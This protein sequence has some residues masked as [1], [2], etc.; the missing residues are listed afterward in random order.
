M[1]LTEDQRELLSDYSWQGDGEME[2]VFVGRQ[3]LFQL[4]AQNARMCVKGKNQGRTVCIAGPPGAGK[5]AF[6]QAL[7]ERAMTDG[8]GGPK[9]ACISI[10]PKELQ[11]PVALLGHIARQLPEAWRPEVGGIRAA[12]GRL[13][14][15]SLNLNLFGVGGAIE[16]DT[17]AVQ[18]REGSFPWGE[19]TALLSGL[20]PAAAACICVD[21]AHQLRPTSGRSD[22]EVLM[23]LHQGDAPDCRGFRKPPIFALLA[24]HSQTPEVLAPSISHRYASGNVR[25]MQPLS[26]EES[27]DYALRTMAHLGTQGAQRE[28]RVAADWTVGECAGFPHHLRNAMASIA[29]EML[30]ADSTALAD[31]DGERIADELS[32]RRAIYYASRIDE[33]DRTFPAAAHFFQAVRNRE[34]LPLLAARTEASKA[35]HAIDGHDRRRLQEIGVQDGADLVERMIADGL[36]LKKG[37][38]ND[39][40]CPI[41]SLAAWL[42]TGR[43]DVGQPFPSAA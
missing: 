2:P 5:T 4:I 22:N 24:G 29:E 7:S 20:P 39:Y 34:K 37:L 42:R 43:H 17:T 10:S 14:I 6:L 26:K 27:T 1:S 12:A 28:L 40:G 9:M 25:Y 33:R 15:S 16:I 19:I 41:P 8:W 36:L 35:L 13:G 38:N 32:R 3:D 11:N 18:V 21:E 30:R 23:A 31:L